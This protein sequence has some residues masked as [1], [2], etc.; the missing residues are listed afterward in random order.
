MRIQRSGRI[1]LLGL[2]A[3]LAACAP[4]GKPDPKA[5]KAAEA[6]EKVRPVELLQ[7]SPTA[8]AEI[9]EVS[10]KLTA[11][12]DVMV[13]A[14]GSGEVLSIV[15]RGSTV[16]AGE[17]IAK[18]DPAL[19]QAG[20][21]QARASIQLAQAGLS[22]ARDTLRRQK[23]LYEKQIISGLEYRRLQGQVE[24]ARAQL[25]QARAAAR[26]ASTQV[27]YTEVLAPFDGVVEQRMVERGEQLAPGKPVV[28][29]VNSSTLRVK[30]GVPE[31]YARDVAAGQ[32]A[33]IDFSTYGLGK[34]EG[35][36]GFVGQAIDSASRTFPVEIDLKNDDG[37]LKPEMSVRVRLARS[38]NAKAIVVPQ[39]AVLRDVDGDS[40][41]V[42]EGTFAKG[43]APTRLNARRVPVVLGRSS[44][45]QVE[46]TSGLDAGMRVIVRGQASLTTGDPVR[47]EVNTPHVEVQVKLDGVSAEQVEQDL[48]K[49]LEA[50]LRT[51]P[52]VKKLRSTSK[53]GLASVIAE[54]DPSIDGDE[55]R[56]RVKSSVGDVALPKGAVLSIEGDR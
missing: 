19:T 51:V 37:A 47:P 15:E 54:F 39:T 1:A 25:A 36:I 10:G 13:A 44:A 12:Q 50:R 28:R 11:P 43:E 41:F 34:R 23:P 46:V 27:R 40:V 17:Q 24:Q 2:I 9:F 20:A 4:P 33:T 21:A 7:V 18:V 6:A 31:R 45:G 5:A 42:A 52:G 35:T 3:S 14:R 32:T 30:A 8:F 26:S 16:K 56:S 55:A 38:A 53:A 48:T 29:L 22:L 49:P